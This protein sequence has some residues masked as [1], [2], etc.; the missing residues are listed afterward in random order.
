MGKTAAGALWLDPQRTSP[1]DFYQYWI[2]VDDADVERFLALFT[3]LPMEEVRRLGGLQGRDIREAK[4]ALAFEATRIT[5]SEEEAR[6]AR[7]ASRSLFG[8]SE[9]EG[10]ES[11][12]TTEIP[13]ERLEQ[14]IP[15]WQLFHE[16][17]LCKSRAEARRLIQQ[18]GG[19]V[20]DRR[21]EAFDERIG[22]EETRA[23]GILV[24]A[25][26][27]SYHRIRLKEDA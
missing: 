5:H 6:K 3:F 4:E 14:G 21:I 24:R 23:T 18:G 20:N 13:R 10:L 27:K 22:M 12:P 1:Y 2:N 8:G 17:G 7:E 9:G 11:A 15:A 25:G 19:Y 16:V 26:K